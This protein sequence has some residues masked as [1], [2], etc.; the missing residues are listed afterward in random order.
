MSS[1]G[2]ERSSG[3]RFIGQRLDEIMPV[4]VVEENVI[5]LIA[6]AH[7]L[8]DSTGIFD[9]HLPQRRPSLSLTS[10]RSQRRNEG[11]FYGLTHYDGASFVLT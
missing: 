9:S 2:C 7:H 5:P 3:G 10:L 6:T 4:H 1:L 8:V 11:V